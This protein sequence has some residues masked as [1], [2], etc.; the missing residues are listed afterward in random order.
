MSNTIN[1]GSVPVCKEAVVIPITADV[2]GIWAF[3]TTFNGAYQYV[4][5]NVEVGK[6]IVVPVRLNEDYTYTFKLY[7]PDNSILN[8]T[9]YSIKTTPLL[10]DVSYSY[11]YSG[12]TGQIVTGQKQFEAT[13][14]QDMVSFIELVNAVQV[15]VFVEG[16]VVQSG[17]AHEEYLFDN[18]TGVVSWNQPLIEGQ[19]VTILYFK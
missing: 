6:T 7:K 1:L 14:G 3:M 8:D 18:I 12:D 13:D 9:S 19:K 5:F 11:A 4:Q 2:T 10:P 16:A 17:N 15:V